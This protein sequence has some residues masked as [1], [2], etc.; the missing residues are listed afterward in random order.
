MGLR[1][2]YG[3]TIFRKVQSEPT[4]ARSSELN[5]TVAPGSFHKRTR[6]VLL[7]R[8]RTS[9]LPSP[10]KSPMPRKVQ[11]EPTSARSSELNGTVAPGSFHKRTSTAV[12]LLRRT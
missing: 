2:D 8:H 6:P 11:S 3:V 1:E 7:L 9:A 12:L 10:S 4:S 5:G